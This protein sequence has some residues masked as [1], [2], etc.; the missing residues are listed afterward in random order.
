MLSRV[1]HELKHSNPFFCGRLVDLSDPHRSR[2]SVRVADTHAL[3]LTLNKILPYI[4]SRKSFSTHFP[5]I[6]SFA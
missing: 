4:P 1:Q 6:N 3:R 2:K 5:S